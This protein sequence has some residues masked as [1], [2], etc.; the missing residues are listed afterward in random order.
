VV[1]LRFFFFLCFDHFL[2]LNI[3]CH[4]TVNQHLC[5]ASLRQ[6]SRTPHAGGYS[7]CALSVQAQSQAYRVLSFIPFFQVSAS[8]HVGLIICLE[9]IEG[10]RRHLNPTTS[11]ITSTASTHCV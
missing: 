9:G 10:V 6:Q 7:I 3:F 4:F 8:F 11:L 1:L 5:V 2:N